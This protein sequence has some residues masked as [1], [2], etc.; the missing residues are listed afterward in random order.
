MNFNQMLNDFIKDK[1]A[2]FDEDAQ[3]LKLKEIE[4]RLERWRMSHSTQASKEVDFNKD[5]F[6]VLAG[7]K[8]SEMTWLMFENQ[9][10]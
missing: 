10:R 7:T 8:S 3:K 2:A 6:S 5:V 9:I 1:S 4:E